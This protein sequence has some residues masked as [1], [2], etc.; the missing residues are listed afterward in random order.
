[1]LQ[2]PQMLYYPHVAN[3]ATWETEIGIIN[4]SGTE[5]SGALVFYADQEN[6]GAFIDGEILWML[7]VSL[8]PHGRYSF[9][10]WDLPLGP[11]VTDSTGYI[12]YTGDG[13]L[14]NTA[15]YEK[16]YTHNSATRV[17]VP[18]VEKPSEGDIYVSHIASNDRWWTGISLV[19]TTTANKDLI[20]DFDNRSSREVSLAPGEHRA[21][22]VQGLFGSKQEDIGSAVISNASGIIGLELF[23]SPG[24][25]SANYLSGVLLKDALESKLYYPH[26][27]TGDNWWTGIVACDPL[28]ANE[29]LLVTPYTENGSPLAP[30]TISL[31]AEQYKM[32]GNPGDLGFP[33]ETA[34]FTVEAA[35]GITGF[36]L[37]GTNDT[38]RLGGYTGV[39]ISG[40]Q[41][42]FAKI[43]DNGWTGIAFVNAEEEP[44][45]VTLTA[46]NDAGESLATT[47]L[48]LG[49]YAKQV[50][51]APN[52]FQN[53]ISGATYIDYSSD[54][55]IVGF[56]LNSS[57]IM[58]DALSGL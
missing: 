18:A 22:S 52:L 30:V 9:H 25:A 10:C 4:Q 13:S 29:E 12:V 27:D 28:L 31:N 2:A 17:A 55:E 14:E 26:I 47:E 32:R 49:G 45:Q 50:D 24:G 44:A 19:N 36:E 8:A 15:G 41:G 11:M 42:S 23:G 6:N 35:S 3:N 39:G 21:F 1:Y 20:I 46:Y 54:R 16:F 58:L 51:V 38:N 33:A 57:G 40:K 53:D 37:F 5:A 56:Q 34:W 48:S 43:E 7:P